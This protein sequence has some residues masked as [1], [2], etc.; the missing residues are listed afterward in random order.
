MLSYI[1]LITSKIVT[2]I[3]GPKRKTSPVH[4][5]LIC[6]LLEYFKKAFS[7]NF[8]EAQKTEI[9]LAEEK[10]AATELFIGGL[11]RGADALAA[12]EKSLDP[13]LELYL[14]AD[15]WCI[16]TPSEPMC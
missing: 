10:P 12:T 14:T 6:R 13:L 7:G 3:V 8:Q 2:L 11:Y 5:A 9:Y 4:K 15:K 1:S 16:Y